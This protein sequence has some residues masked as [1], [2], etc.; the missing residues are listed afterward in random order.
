MD[1]PT[2][3]GYS[4]PSLIADM[5][6]IEHHRDRIVDAFSAHNVSIIC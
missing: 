2:E 5:A 3:Y 1:E 4:T 6:M